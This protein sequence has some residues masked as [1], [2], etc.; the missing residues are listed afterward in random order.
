VI[1]GGCRQ[2]GNWDGKVDLEFAEDI[3]RRCCALCPELGKPEELQVVSHGVGLRRECFFSLGSWSACLA[4]GSDLLSF[5]VLITLVHEA[6]RFALSHQRLF[7]LKAYPPHGY[8][9]YKFLYYVL[10]SHFPLRY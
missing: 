7:P 4:L 9:R 10:F 2:E 5:L 3:K 8:F 6:C 1:L